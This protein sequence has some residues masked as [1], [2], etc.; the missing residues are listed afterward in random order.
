MESFHAHQTDASDKL[1]QRL[2]K[3]AAR[4]EKL[5]DDL[6]EYSQAAK[7][8]SSVEAVDLNQLTQGV[9]EDLELEIQNKQA[10]VTT[11][12]LPVIQGNTRQLQQLFQN[13]ISNA[14]KYGKASVPP[15]VNI[16]YKTVT[17]KDALPELTGEEAGQFYHLIE[18][19]DNG[20][21]FDQHD[22]ERIFNLFTRLRSDVEYRGSG[23]GLSIVKKVVESHHGFIRARSEIGKGA[24]FSIL[25]PV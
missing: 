4:M 1:F 6:L 25:L 21:G 13:L 5:I 3:S 23:V 16:R 15:V 11:M 20:I 8:A 24:V 17:G 14:L 19:S 18:V 7:G 9:L 2:D 22:A 10:T 12:P